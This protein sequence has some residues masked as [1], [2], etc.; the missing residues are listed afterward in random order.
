MHRCLFVIIAAVAFG[1]MSTA[2]A[3]A[4]TQEL[5]STTPP[6]CQCTA[7]PVFVQPDGRDLVGLFAQPK[8]PPPVAPGASLAARLYDYLSQEEPLVF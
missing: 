7:D 4:A 5:D 3:W 2:V 1:V 6:T 8:P